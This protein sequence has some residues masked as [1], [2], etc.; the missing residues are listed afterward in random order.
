MKWGD[1]LAQLIKLHD[2]VSRY[3]WNVYRYP[4]QFIRLKQTNWKS[5]FDNWSNDRVIEPQ[6]ET[7]AFENESK[8]MKIKD[9]FKPKSQNL[10]DSESTLSIRSE[11]ELRQY[12]LDQLFP[13]QLK[14]ATSTITDTSILDKDYEQDETLKYFL[15]RFPDL[16]LIMYYPVFNIRNAPVDGEII[17]IGPTNIEIITLMEFEATTSIM[18][19]DERTWS[20]ESGQDIQ[21][22]ISPLIALRRTEHIIKSILRSRGVNFPI[23]KTIL[24]RTN[25]IIFT[26]E[27]FNTNIIGRREYKAWFEHKRN[28]SSPLKNEQL[29]VAETL[30]DYCVSTSIKRPEWEQDHDIFTMGE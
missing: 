3:G 11:Y 24:S 12:F 18:A 9:L 2:Y 17:F 8:L 15:Q 1:Y 21:Q 7:S 6:A 30:L 13:F 10:E 22:I 5:L 29:K 25:S 23:N 4:S 19:G 14:W 28:I 16:Y 26:T 20:I 27:P